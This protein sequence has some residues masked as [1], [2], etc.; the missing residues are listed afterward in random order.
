MASWSS[1]V[2][3]TTRHYWTLP[4]PNDYV[5]LHQVLDVAEQERK[6]FLKLGDD[7]PRWDNDLMVDVGDAEIIV[8][9]DVKED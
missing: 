6:R 9:F 1:G 2:S 7:A 8:Y 4:T 5:Q 3:T